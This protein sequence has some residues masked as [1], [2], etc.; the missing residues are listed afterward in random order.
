MPA[1]NQL[2]WQHVADLAFD[3]FYVANLT[4]DRQRRRLL[5]GL[6]DRIGRLCL[7]ARTGL[8][9]T[10]STDSAA[11]LNLRFLL[12]QVQQQLRFAHSLHAL[13]APL[14]HRLS[15][16]TAALSHAFAHPRVGALFAGDE[17]GRP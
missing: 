8:E 9:R 14:Y 17:V 13:E 15:S 4:G 11:L 5:E 6:K 3:C 16:R 1:L 2:L 10:R 7:A 12:D